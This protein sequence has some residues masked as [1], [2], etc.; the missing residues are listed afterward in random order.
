[1]SI[2]FDSQGC[3]NAL[4]LSLINAMKD[5][6]EELLA[7]SKQ[8]ML[9]PEGKESLHN[10]KIT[11]IANVITAS[12]AG[13]A[14]AAMDEFGTGSLMDTSNSALETYKNSPAWN[15]ARRDNKIRTRPNTPG[16]VDIFGNP[17]RGYGKGGFDLEQLG[18]E[19]SPT[20]PSHAIKTTIRWMKNGR[21]KEKIKETI[22]NFP[23]H[24]F[25]ITDNK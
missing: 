22:T 6:Q 10:E 21:M 4:R 8:R 1:M 18:D 3:I 20:P 13:G 9:T 25:I 11:D 5:L 24:K 2:R 7:E 16:Q 23:F 17:V 14:W 15:P 19:Y 12:I